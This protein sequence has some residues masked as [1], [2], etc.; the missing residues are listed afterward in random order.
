MPARTKPVDLVLEGGGVKAIGLA[1]AY[2]SLVDHGFQPVNVAGASAG[3]TA[4]ALIAA[5]YTPA[6]LRDEILELD[7]RQF[8]DEA[9]EDKLPLIDRTASLLLDL[10][11]HEGRRFR[12][13]VAERLEAKGVRTFGDLVL[14]AAEEDLRFRYRLQVIVSDVTERALLVLPRDAGRLGLEP[15]EL[16]VA[17]AIRMSVSIP[18]FFEPVRHT[19][20]RTGREHILVDGG[21]LSNFPVWLF[22]SRERGRP[23]F[24]L[25]LV[26]P[27]P[28]EHLGERIE[29]PVRARGV[30]A[31]IDYLKAL[32]Q[33]MMAAHDRLY[34][35]QAE[36]ARTI[37]I[38]TL[39][40]GTTEFD[41]ERE[42][43]EALYRSGVEAAEEFLAAWDPVAYERAFGGGRRRSRPRH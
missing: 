38:P 15:D 12:A 20:P 10:G 22:D 35:E 8:R 7:Y 14:D 11:I 18:I 42:R 9:W 19:N 6:Q 43:R 40:V 24:G 4:A 21:M 16:S 41:L 13:W 2:E 17:D 32:A 1:G 26:E 31:L 29:S 3:A 5:G 39:G 33:T 25:L 34:L 28:R 30:G 37:A 23:T 36:F 27:A